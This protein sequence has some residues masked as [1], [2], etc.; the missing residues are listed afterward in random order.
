MEP[1]CEPCAEPGD[2][3]FFFSRGP[4]TFKV[5][6]RVPGD[7]RVKLVAALGKASGAV[8]LRGGTEKMR[9]DTDHE[10]LFRQESYF[11]HLFAVR[12]PGC[13]GLIELPSGRTTLFIPKLEPEYAIW[14]GKIE[15]PDSFRRRYGVDACC[16]VEELKNAVA[17]ISGPIYVLSGTNTD[18]GLNLAEELPTD[19][20]LPDGVSLD[21]STLYNI[22]AECRVH[23]SA[24]EVEVMRYV[25]WVSSC[26]HASVMRDTKPGMF[27]YQLEALFL[28]HCA[29]HGGCRLSAY[30]QICACGP[31]A[32]VLHY[33]HAGAPNDRQLLPND[34]A[35]LD[36]GAEYQFY[37]SD[38]T[39]SFPVSG[40]FSL[41]Q[42]Q[43]YT[44]VLEAQRRVMGAMRPGTSWV[45]MHE[46][47]HRAIL[48]HLASAGLLLGDVSE[49]MAANLGQTFMPHGLGHLIGVDTHDVGGY[50]PHTPA[51]PSALGASKLRTA[52]ILDVG[53]VLT[54][55]PG[56]YFID[57]LLDTALADPTR[58]RFLVPAAIERMR[59]FGGVRLEDVVVVT[60]TGID[61]LTLC[62]R[63]LPEVEAV[64]RGGE[65]PP[66]TDAAP[67]LHRRWHTLDKA[68]GAMVVDRRVRVDEA[69]LVIDADF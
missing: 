44:A 1:I 10:E 47:A 22:A 11:A 56:C 69:K 17:A 68:S 33:G 32:A 52:R 27:E 26:A 48:E 20:A 53:M 46:L 39:C 63:T 42:K 18:S 15:T 29:F 57:M 50:L 58:S 24:D 51:R 36:M 54:V 14:M 31:D 2:A 45:E 12:E 62:P 30:T 5:P 4:G 8:L 7:A 64:M 66:A 67:W 3:A 21:T 60:A 6:G 40:E 16:F 55:E 38:I 9:D 65:W 61:N 43:V 28:F 25:A 34:I 23:K 41:E 37:A 59:G 19:E 35:L 13:W 49:M